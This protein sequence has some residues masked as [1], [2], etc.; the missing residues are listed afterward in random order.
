[1]DDA[2]ELAQ[3]QL[4]FEAKLE[5]IMARHGRL[6]ERS[7]GLGLMRG[8]R[9]YDAPSQAAIVDAAFEAGVIVLKAG[10]NTVRFLPSLT[11]TA[12]EITEGFERFEKAIRTL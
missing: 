7:V 10:R 2:G 4:F 6:F 11:M 3:T 12:E 1:M 8:L 9:A 5:E